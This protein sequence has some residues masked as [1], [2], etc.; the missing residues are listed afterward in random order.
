[1]DD[2]QWVAREALVQKMR[3]GLWSPW[4]RILANKWL[5]PSNGWWEN[6][7]ET[8]STDKHCDYV[9]IHR[10]DPPK[11]HMGGKGNAGPYLDYDGIV[12]NTM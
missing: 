3:D 12:G 1:M 5:I 4:F 6:L 10:F 7:N 2:V 9:N 8:I 11:E